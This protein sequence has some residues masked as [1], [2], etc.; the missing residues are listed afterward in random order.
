[1]K[2]YIVDELR[3]ADQEKIGKL[4]AEEFGEAVMD[5]LYWVPLDPERYSD[6]QAEHKDC[7]PFYFALE[8]ASDA[9]ACELL[10]RTKS[11][12][13]CDCISYATEGQ[14]NWLIHLVDDLFEQAEIIT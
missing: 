13:R 12:V 9:L 11:R 1:M 14:R 6:V 5:N 10:A 8:L 3:P 2:Q 4:L 7:Q